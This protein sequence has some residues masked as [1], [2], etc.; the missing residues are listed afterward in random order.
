M[1]HSISPSPGRLY[2]TKSSESVK[3]REGEHH[4][5]SPEK[6]ASPE[7]EI[8]AI[9]DERALD[10][11]CLGQSLISHGLDMD[12]VLFSSIEMW[13]NAFTQ[14]FRG[15]LLNVGSRDFLHASMNEEICQFIAEFPEIPVIILSDNQDIHQ[16][17]AALEIGAKG[18]IPSTVGIGI[19]VEAISLA[20]AGG[21]F[22][23]TECLTHIQNLL[24]TAGQ[25]QH[26]RSEMFTSREQQVIE[27]LRRGKANK[28]IAYELNLSESTVKVHIRNI[29][30]KLNAHNRTEAMFKINSQFN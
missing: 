9:I 28:I 15:I 25:R 3:S 17:F 2:T 21:I 14:T 19:C 29:M 18:Y 6:A 22:I 27:A 4:I 16:I 24:V 8:L 26:R 1:L 5:R 7:S 12:I 11:E 30:K 10:R 23:S 13:K 20:L